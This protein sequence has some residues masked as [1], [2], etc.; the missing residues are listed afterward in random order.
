MF[1]NVDNPGLIQKLIV[2]EEE[3]FQQLLKATKTDC[4]R[5][6]VKLN[7]CDPEELL[8]RV[9]LRLV[10]YDYSKF[11]PKRG[12]FSAFIATI[13]WRVFVDWTR[14]AEGRNEVQL[15]LCLDLQDPVP[16]GKQSQFIPRPE[17]EVLLNELPELDRCLVCRRGIDQIGFDQLADESGLSVGAVKRRF[18]RAC[19]K[20]RDQKK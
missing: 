19:K 16:N 6:F 18:Y 2:R 11:D 17:V 14:E 1:E 13:A 4:T 12:C 8:G 3:G 5:L 7:V 10:E 9:L 20:L 15:G